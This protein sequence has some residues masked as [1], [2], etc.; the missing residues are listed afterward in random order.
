[1]IATDNNG[2]SWSSTF[3]QVISAPDLAGGI[4]SIDDAVGGD[5]DGMLEPGE[6]AVITLRCLNN[7]HSD[8]LL[9]TASIT[10]LSA[11][12]TLIS[13]SFQTGTLPSGG[14]YVDAQFQ[15]ALASNVTV[16]TQWD[17]LLNLSSG[18][19]QIT[20]LY[21]GTAGLILEDFETGNFNRFNWI[22][23][24]NGPW[25][26]TGT[27]P[28]E[29]S[30]CAQS[31]VIADDETSDLII[32]FSSLADDSLSF[33]YKVSSEQDW[34]FLRVYIDGAPVDGWSG[35]MSGWA[36]IGYQLT[37]GPHTINFSYEKDVMIVAG[38]DCAWLDN[39]RL[40]I[41]TQTT[42]IAE[43]ITRNGVGV[44]PN[45]ASGV[46]NVLVKEV[47]EKDMRWTLSTVDGKLVNTG[48]IPG[49][50]TAQSQFTMDVSGLSSG[51][52]FLT[53]GQGDMSRVVKVVVE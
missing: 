53:I 22:M 25:I 26:T 49:A 4:M 51:L 6:T 36:Y 3:T 16:G 9:S 34:D 7:G 23:G 37:A 50:G 10:T 42:S 27:A 31:G 35:I 14:G 5:G 45:P 11:Y 19:Y 21:V 48:L 41:G 40:P 29:G 13:T 52:Y 43:V 38:N 24:G 28:F 15:V 46:L 33:W 17:V 18:S 30:W 1:V 44:W 39:I 20:K 2:N 12:L 47:I 8:A 32:S